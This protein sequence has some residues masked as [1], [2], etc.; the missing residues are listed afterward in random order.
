MW[1]L[2][3]STPRKPRWCRG[4]QTDLR[5]LMSGPRVLVRSE[6]LSRNT[7]GRTRTEICSQSSGAWEVRRRGV[8]QVRVWLPAAPRVAPCHCVLLT[9]SPIPTG[10]EAEG[11]A[12]PTRPW[13][14]PLQCCYSAHEADPRH[15]TPPA[16]PTVG[17][18]PNTWHPQ[19]TAPEGMRPTETRTTTPSPPL[20]FSSTHY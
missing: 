4:G 13:P 6:L 9:G 17:W 1:K 20:F 15:E 10:Q 2:G 18:V 16:L 14:S 12:R 5:I 7:R 19:T 3:L 8:S 11:Q